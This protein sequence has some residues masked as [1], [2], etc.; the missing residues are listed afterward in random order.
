MN[1][2]FRPKYKTLHAAVILGCALLELFFLV[3]P[4]AMCN[5]FNSH[6]RKSIGSPD[7]IEHTT[8]LTPQCWIVPRNKPCSV[9]LNRFFEVE[10]TA[11]NIS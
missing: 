9:I 5:E 4:R 11:C 1:I 10:A 6:E 3:P 8:E 7:I 2:C